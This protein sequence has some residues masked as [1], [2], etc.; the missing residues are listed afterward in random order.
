MKMT[1]HINEHVL[2]DVMT[3]H[4][5]ETKTEAIDFALKETD[6]R[7]KLRAYKKDG[8]GLTPE[9][10]MEAV[11]EDITPYSSLVAEPKMTYNADKKKKK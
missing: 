5:F 7:A 2:A 8:L 9:E 6:R 10:L 4:G 11:E 3:A 1:L